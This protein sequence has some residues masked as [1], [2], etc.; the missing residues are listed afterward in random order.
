MNDIQHFAKI[1]RD[2]KFTM[3]TTIDKVSGELHSRPMTLQ[4]M[5][6]DGDLWFF[7]QKYSELAQQVEANPNVNLSFANTDTFSFLSGQGVAELIIGDK[8]KERELWKPLYRAWFP[9]GLDDPQLCLIRVKI[10]SADYWESPESKLVRMVGFAKAILSGSKANN[11]L[12]E[13]GH[14]RIQQ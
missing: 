10:T 2:T 8:A 3:F 4:E 6:F 7:A 12:G 9:E 14:L 5:E 13:R 11:A 1:I